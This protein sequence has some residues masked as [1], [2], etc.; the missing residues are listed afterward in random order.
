MIGRTVSHYRI[1]R[2]LGAGG[3]GVVYEAVDTKLGRTVALKFL[4]PESVRDPDAKA[5][6]SHEA[7]AASSLDHPNICT[8]H[9]IEESDDG[10]LFI[11]MARYEGETL[12]HLIARGPVDLPVAVDITTQTLQGLAKAHRLGIVH[13]DIK[14]ANV[15]VT[16]EGLVKLLDVG[17]AKLVGQTQ[18][19][20]TG[21]V[22]GTVHYMAPEQ[23]Q[24]EEV[25][26]RADLWSVGVVMY[27]MLTGRRPFLA[28]HPPALMYA[29]LNTEPEPLADARDDLPPELTAAVARC[30]DKSPAAR[31]QGAEDLLLQL[32][33][34]ATAA[35]TRVADART[36]C[37]RGEA[38][39]LN[40]QP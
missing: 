16:E 15:F 3:M 26:R 32:R 37:Q 30:L 13:R 8:I 10:R 34:L 17:I 24:G 22:V 19:T 7:K 11:A 38:D 18:I 6:F 36:V 35:A 4:P 14:P 25:D 9:A 21:A 31:P 12:G 27:E 2:E 39:T 23:L 28:D 29:I 40:L 1:T 33:P 20:R 5:R